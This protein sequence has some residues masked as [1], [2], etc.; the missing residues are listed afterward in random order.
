MGCRVVDAFCSTSIIVAFWHPV[1]RHLEPPRRLTLTVLPE[2]HVVLQ[3]PPHGPLPSGLLEVS[4]T[5]G[6]VSISRTVTE[7]TVVCPSTAVPA[8][9]APGWRAKAGWRVI[10]F[11]G[12]FDFAETGVLA[13]VAAPLAVGG[14]AVFVISTYDTDYLLV[15]GTDLAA[16]VGVLGDAG[17]RVSSVDTEPTLT[18]ANLDAMS[19]EVRSET[20]PGSTTRAFNE[21]LIA[22]FRANAGV[23]SGEFARSRFLLLTTTGARSGRQR[24]TP[25]AYLLIDGRIFIVASMGGA[26]R[27][28]AW[29]LNLVAHPTVTVELG[30]ETYQAE[31]VTMQGS[32]RDELFER[33]CAKIANFADYQS[34][35]DRVIPVVELRR[36]DD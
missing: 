32:E 34:R 9:E 7:L 22:E 16:T 15:D 28:P 2:T 18:L 21:A 8:V 10:R 20:G 13:S 5:G 17:H 25:L 36:L 27:H 11:E 12:P 24:T 35:T 6:L 19:N 23:L 4:A 31:A 3:G 30:S 33:I 29:Y 14:I 26:P 1:S